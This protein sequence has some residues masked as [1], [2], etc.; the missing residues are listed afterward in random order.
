MASRQT[1]LSI[2]LGGEQ[3]DV[4][5]VEATEALGRPFAIS[6]DLVA[7]L[8]EIDFLPHLGKP[9]SVTILQDDE[10]MRYFNGIVVESEFVSEQ[11]DGWHYRLSLRPWTYL[12]SN[13]KNFRIFQ[14][15][16]VIDIA[17]ETFAKCGLVKVNYDNASTGRIKRG[18]CVQ[19]GESD[20]TF[21]TRLFEEEGIY[22]YFDH[23]EDKHEMVLCVQPS[24][25][26]V[27]TPQNITFNPHSENLANVDSAIRTLSDRK[28]YISRWQ[29]RVSTGGQAKVTMRDFD[30]KT[31][32]SVI[33]VDDHETEQH[34]EDSNEIYEFPGRYWSKVSGKPLSTARLV[35]LRAG[36]QTYSGETQASSLACGRVFALEEHPCDRLNQRYL[37]TR[38]HHI[39]SAE[40]YASGGSAE[41]STVYIET[42]PAETHW[43]SLPTVPRPV[44]KGPET[45]IVSG[46]SGEHIYTDK[47]GR[48]KV[49]FHWDRGQ[50]SGEGSTCWIRVSQTG[51]LGNVILPRVGHE[52]IV[53]FLYGDPDRPII[54]GRV[55]NSQH[56][57]VYSLPD[58]KT[59]ALWR[60]ER[61]GAAGDYGAAQTL[62]T[63]KP[64][65]NELRFDDKGGEEEVFLHAERDMKIRVRHKESH[66]IGLDQEIKIGQDRSEYVKRN[67]KV[68]IDGGRKVDIKESDTLNVVGSIKV[69]SQ[70]EIS[71]EAVSKITLKVGESKITIDGTSI[72]IESAMIQME[73]QAT[74][75]VKSPMTTVKGDGILT[76]KGGLTMIN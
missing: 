63:G 13:N 20:F 46:P 39:C 6:L 74:V 32:D 72:K 12:L 56:M 40:T 42:I 18:Y 34:A 65:A 54:V 73:G 60:T 25:H 68:G 57:P 71:I 1:I 24:N 7:K 47:F 52:V 66:H 15:K 29:E 61:Y 30:F 4:R 3:V 31:A 55:F 28:H 17:K 53:D 45:A 75:D 64:G 8:G 16:T 48:V 10:L 67:E 70:A 50:T 23:S 51:G 19:Y 26:Q 36:R 27:A 62:D 11:Q 2:D 44:V 69:N 37:I 49:R 9:A 41:G 5:R 59:K 22:Y 14:D 35:A 21:I 38:T 58:H 43:H 76:L 33:E